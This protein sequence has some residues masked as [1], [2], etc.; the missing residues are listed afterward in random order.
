[1]K[2]ALELE[3]LVEAFENGKK[4]GFKLALAEFRLMVEGLESKF[5]VPFQ[6]LPS[7]EVEKLAKETGVEIA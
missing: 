6:A 2:E 1:M 4:E 7:K 3:H 5:L